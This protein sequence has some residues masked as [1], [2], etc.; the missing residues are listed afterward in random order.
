[1]DRY[2]TDRAFCI[3]RLCTRSIFNPCQRKH[4]M[5]LHSM[6]SR[7]PDCCYKSITLLTADKIIELLNVDNVCRS[8]AI[9]FLFLLLLSTCL[10]LTLV[11]WLIKTFDAC[12]AKT[13]TLVKRREME[14]RWESNNGDNDD[15]TNERMGGTKKKC[16]IIIGASVSQS[17]R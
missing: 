12:E 10:L 17:N 1:M 5:N 3:V 9:S 8:H 16:K 2:N 13:T 6:L 7:Q 11:E 4:A 15:K 14:D